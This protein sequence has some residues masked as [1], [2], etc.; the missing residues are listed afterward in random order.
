LV[1]ISGGDYLLQR[2]LSDLITGY[3][4]PAIAESA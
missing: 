2:Q 4:V 3:L 1:V